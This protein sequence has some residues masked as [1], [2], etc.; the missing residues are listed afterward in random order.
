MI[1]RVQ[2]NG[3]HE[4]VEASPDEAKQARQGWPALYVLLAGIIGAVAALALIFDY[5]A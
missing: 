5:F 4:H 3:Q 2:D 1:K